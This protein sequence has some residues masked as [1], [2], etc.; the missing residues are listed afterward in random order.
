MS[1]KAHPPDLTAF[2]RAMELSAGRE[3]GST[4]VDVND[5]ALVES[6]WQIPDTIVSSYGWVIGP[7]TST[8]T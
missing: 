2:L 8:A 4:G 5:I 1:D 7:T 6:A 3:D